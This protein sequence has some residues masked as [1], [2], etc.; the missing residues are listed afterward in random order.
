MWWRSFP[1]IVPNAVISSLVNISPLALILPD[2]VTL[3]F[4]TVF[5]IESLPKTTLLEPSPIAL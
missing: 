5:V 3:P 4:K 1:F 2:A